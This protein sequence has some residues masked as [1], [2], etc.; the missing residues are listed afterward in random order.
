MV[1]ENTLK[2]TGFQ[3]G[4][5]ILWIVTC[6]WPLPW[7]VASLPAPTADTNVSA[8]VAIPARRRAGLYGRM[9]RF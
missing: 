8:T 2:S 5:P 7:A 4:L 6:V 9:M 1:P 3:L